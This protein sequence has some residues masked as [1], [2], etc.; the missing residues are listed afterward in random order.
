MAHPWV[1]G[2][3]DGLQIWRVA[4]NILNKQS[5][6]ADIEWSSSLGVGWGANNPS[7]KNSMFV[8]K[9]Y[10]Q[11]QAGCCEYGDEPSGSCAME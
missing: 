11:P 7:L 2:T 3:G 10:T 1:A 4:A 6:T 8:T 9:R 5:W